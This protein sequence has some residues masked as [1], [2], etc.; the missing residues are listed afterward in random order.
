MFND[1]IDFVRKIF[2]NKKPITLQELKF[3]CNTKH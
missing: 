3:I 1:F 2:G